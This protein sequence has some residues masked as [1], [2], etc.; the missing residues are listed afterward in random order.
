[1]QIRKIGGRIIAD[2][3]PDQHITAAQG[4]QL[5][6]RLPA[7]QD[8]QHLLGDGKRRIELLRLIQRKFD[9]NRNDNVDIHFPNGLNRQVGDQA[10]VNQ[11]RAINRHRGENSGRRHACAHGHGEIAAPEN[12]RFSGIEVGGNGAKRHRQIIEVL[13][14]RNL[15]RLF[16]QYQSQFLALDDAFW[17]QQ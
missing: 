12:A 10:T 17:Q 11:R 3:G 14:M 9:I 1:M 8:R 5:P 4:I 7:N 13:D 15:Q 6:L 2:G 16:A